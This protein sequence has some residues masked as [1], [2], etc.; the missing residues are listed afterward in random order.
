MCSLLRVYNNIVLIKY[1]VCVVK[2]TNTKLVIRTSSVGKCT[3]TKC[4]YSVINKKNNNMML[5]SLHISTYICC[6]NKIYEHITTASKLSVQCRK[7]V[8]LIIFIGP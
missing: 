5:K 2:L 1:Y 7:T 3:Y 6:I 8:T 4:T